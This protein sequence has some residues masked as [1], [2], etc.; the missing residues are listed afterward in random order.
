MKNLLE[1]SLDACIR[2]NT[3]RYFSY[4]IAVDVFGLHLKGS[5][6]SDPFYLLSPIGRRG[7]LTKC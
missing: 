5:D 1:K 3:K 7:V 4:W 2:G 6:E